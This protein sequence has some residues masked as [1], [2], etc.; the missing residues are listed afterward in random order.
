MIKELEYAESISIPRD[1]KTAHA[2]LKV[3][4]FMLAAEQPP[5]DPSKFRRG[6]GH[7]SAGT[8]RKDYKHKA[9][10]VLAPY[11]GKESGDGRDQ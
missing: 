11:A 6:Y 3:L 9:P 4:G 10:R 7:P 5:I 2:A 1:Q 8:L